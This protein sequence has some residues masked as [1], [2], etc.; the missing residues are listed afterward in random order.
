MSEDQMRYRVVA[1]TFHNGSMVEPMGADGQPVYVFDRPGLDGPGSPFKAEPEAARDVTLESSLQFD[2]GAAGDVANLQ[3]LIADKTEQL[4]SA[5]VAIA[6]LQ[7][8]LDAER[9]THQEQNAELEAMLA[10]ATAPSAG[11]KQPGPG[12][13]KGK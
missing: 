1:K 5:E 2:S 13:A 7:G 8:R 12:S 11:S 6:D 9:S 3:A 10:A 4:A